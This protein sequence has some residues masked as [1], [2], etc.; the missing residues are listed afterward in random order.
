MRRPD[1]TF[2]A[3]LFAIAAIAQ[4]L[5]A[6]EAVA[7]VGVPPAAATQAAPAPEQPAALAALLA[8]AAALAAADRRVEAYDLLAAAEDSYIGEIEFDYALG[9]A[10]LAAGHPDKATLA[11]FRVVAREPGHAGALIDIGRAYLELRNF[12]QARTT[13]ENLLALNPP[14]ELRAQLQAYLEQARQERPAAQQAL[15]G[16]LLPRGYLAATLGRSNNV[17]QSPGQPQV[18]VPAFGATF[19]LASQNLKKADSFSG[20]SG[21]V[22]A[23]LPLGANY[24]LVGA[25]DFSERRNERE[26]AFNLGGLG[27]NLGLLAANE[28]HSLRAQVSSGR[29]YLGGSPNR[30]TTALGLDYQR[31]IAPDTRLLAF[32]Q[33]GRLRYLPQSLRLFD[34][35]F[36]Y[37]GIGAT[38]QL[39][40]KSTLFAVIST[41]HQN[42]IGGN[43]SGDRRQIGLR[44]GTEVPISADIKI[45][46]N[47]ALERGR[48]DRVDPSFLVERHDLR[49]S[50]ELALQYAL[51]QKMA[52]I[53]GFSQTDQSANIPIYEYGRREGSVTLRYGF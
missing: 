11:L 48:Y 29:D 10:A 43:P 52:L 13:F 19:E 15:A 47:F 42:D 17:N 33:A 23:T 45:S 7:Q 25:A 28:Q 44:V 50:Y 26:S 39:A 5:L 24:A 51:S 12:A 38:H 3:S 2:A 49:R 14:P 41:G 21:G 32:T 22:D 8:R 6:C 16:G 1:Q 27:G 46:G 37:A 34:V 30:Y 20:V 40:G 18:Y 4:A 53:F 9:R 36:V 31:Q 35:S